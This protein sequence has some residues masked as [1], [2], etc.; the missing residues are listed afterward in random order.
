MHP[1]HAGEAEL[2]I[3]KTKEILILA[4]QQEL[5]ERKSAGASPEEVAG[6]IEMQQ[7]HHMLAGCTAHVHFYSK[8]MHALSF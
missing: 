3:R 7:C 5:S 1:K 6:D 2:G 8:C 4:Q